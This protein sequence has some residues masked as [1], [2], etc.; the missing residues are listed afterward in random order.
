MLKEQVNDVSKADLREFHQEDLQLRRFRQLARIP[1]SPHPRSG[2]I[3][4]GNRHGGP[5]QHKREI[6]RRGKHG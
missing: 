4:T 6:A 1:N 3:A 5:H 2:S